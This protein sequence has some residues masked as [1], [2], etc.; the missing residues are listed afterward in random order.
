MN[1]R[2]KPHKD[3]TEGPLLSQIILFALP[4]IA[5]SVLQ[6]LFNTADTIMVGRWGGETPEGCADALAAVGACGALIKLIGDFFL[7]IG[8]GAG[9]LVAH[10]V[11]ARDY[12]DV[13]KTVHTS[14]LLSFVAGV[15]TMLVGFFASP[16]ILEWMQTPALD[17]AIPYIRAYFF[18]MPA[19]VIYYYCAA[20]L[21]SS[22]D[23]ARPL[24]FLSV[25]GV[26]NVA[27][28][29]VAVVTLKMGAMGVGLSTAISQWVS[30]F[31]IIGY[32]LRADIPCHIDLKE[33]HIDLAKLKKILLLGIPA[34]IQYTFFAIS[35]VLIQAAM[36]PLG[37]LAVAGNTAACNLD[38]YVYATQNA[39]YQTTLTF[40]GQHLGACKFKRM[41]KS[42]LLCVISVTTIG[43]AV[44]IGM[45]LLGE[46][47]LQLYTPDNAEVIHFGMVRLQ[48]FCLSFFIGGLM[49]TGCGA[50]NGLGKSVSPMVI[51]LIG[52]CLFRVVWIY[53][54]F[55][56]FQPILPLSDALRV[57]Y[58]S[59]PISWALTALVQF[60]FCFTNLKKAEKEAT[61]QPE[62]I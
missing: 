28:N 17:Q 21:R 27:L 60:L 12:D 13:K 4:L 14:L 33:L 41:K 56:Y 20:M 55:A 46:P 44:G 53:T 6:L 34:G 38:S 11:G 62:H 58:L 26:V 1:V 19:T 51:T 2:T 48:V 47:L 31:L 49:E 29:Y 23:S 57:L 18:G 37:S 43:L 61:L 3:L 50:L 15:V 9:I 45:L 7:G 25:A 36:N 5:T 16:Y 35:N 54:V 24:I 52:S 10:G 22:G 8:I 39:F 30:C 32:M 42:I 40:V 59:Y